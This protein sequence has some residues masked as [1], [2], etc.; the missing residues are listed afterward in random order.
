[1]KKLVEKVK[2]K[3]SSSDSSKEKITKRSQLQEVP[4]APPGLAVEAPSLSAPSPSK[5]EIPIPENMLPEEELKQ[6][7]QE[8][9]EEPEIPKHTE[10]PKLKC[11]HCKKGLKED[12]DF[13]PYCGKSINLACSNCKKELE[14]DF[15]FCP[16]CGETVK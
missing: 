12:F 9:P 10:T 13:C 14:E 4:P 16:Y 5:R 15:E 3:L 11:P 6:K 2:K 1:M 7:I 8:I